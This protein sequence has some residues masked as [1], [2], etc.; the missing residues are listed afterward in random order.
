M[1]A[2]GGSS[3]DRI[4]GISV[5]YLWITYIAQII[6]IREGGWGPGHSYP[7]LENP[8]WD[9]HHPHRRPQLNK[10]R[11]QQREMEGLLD[12]VRQLTRDLRLQMLVI[13]AFMPPECQVKQ[14][15][16]GINGNET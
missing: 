4:F 15:Y 7:K 1:G 16:K 11:K 13:D 5:F 14:L 9:V 8:R 3:R 2:Q 12:N 6:Y 10:R